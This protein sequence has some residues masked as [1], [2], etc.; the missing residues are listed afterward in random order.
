MAL[1]SSSLF[2]VLGGRGRRAVTLVLANVGGHKPEMWALSVLTS[3][4]GERVEI[5][6]NLLTTLRRE[7][8]RGGHWG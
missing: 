2:K 1:L 4:M 3:I 8:A 7:P 6:E 5:N